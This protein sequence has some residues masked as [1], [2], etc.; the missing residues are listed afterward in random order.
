MIA[1]Y[2]VFIILLVSMGAFKSKLSPGVSR[3]AKFGAS[4]FV[5]FWLWALEILTVII[6]L[7]IRTQK[8]T[9]SHSDIYLYGIGGFAVASIWV[10]RFLF[11]KDMTSI[12]KADVSVFPKVWGLFVFLSVFLIFPLEA[13]AIVQHAMF[14][15][16]FPCVSVVIAFI[17]GAFFMELLYREQNSTYDSRAKMFFTPQGNISDGQI[18]LGKLGTFGTIVSSVMYQTIRKPYRLISGMELG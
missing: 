10:A 14:R 11:A 8:D 15:S 12:F 2:V 7:H 4:C 9:P 3:Y 5:V 13:K 17:L 6:H 1:S 18:I 16:L